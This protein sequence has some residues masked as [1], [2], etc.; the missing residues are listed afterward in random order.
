LRD[1]G[2]RAVGLRAARRR[3]ALADL[4]RMVGRCRERGSVEQ[5]QQQGVAI[6]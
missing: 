2:H 3:R 5:V 1:D 6:W 4:A